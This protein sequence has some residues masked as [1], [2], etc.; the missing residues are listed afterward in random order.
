MYKIIANKGNYQTDFNIDDLIKVAEAEEGFIKTKNDEIKERVTELANSYLT[1][2]NNQLSAAGLKEQF[3]I[4]CKSVSSHQNY[5]GLS[6]GHGR[7]NIYIQFSTEFD[8]KTRLFDSKIKG[9][10]VVS[11]NWKR[12]DSGFKKE[13]YNIE[14]V[15]QILEKG[16]QVVLLLKIDDLDMDWKV[17]SNAIEK[18]IY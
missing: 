16:E 17:K 14:S 6:I 11:K 15:A 18:L 1:E 9:E 13:E 3:K 2:L 8:N 12:E 10:F 7:G 4:G 5:V